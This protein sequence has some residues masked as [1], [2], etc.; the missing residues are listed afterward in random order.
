MSLDSASPAPSPRLR[1]IE[2]S[3]GWSLGGTDQAIEIRAA[4]L[5]PEHFD[6]EAVGLWGGQRFERLKQHGTRGRELGGKLS[7]LGRVLSESRPHVLHYTRADRNCEYSAAV[8]RAA[9]AAAVPVLVETNVFGRPA[10]FAEPR[11]PD[12]TC[13]M[14]LASMLRCAR[15]L[16]T[17]MEEL[18]QRGH[19]AVYLP[20]PTPAGYGAP[21][22]VPRAEARQRLGV[23]PHEL[24]ACRITRPDLRKWSVRLELALPRLFQAVPELRFVFMAAPA[25]KIGWLRR[26]FG[27]RVICVEPQTDLAELA[28]VYAASDL[29]IHSSGIGESFGLSMAEGMFHGLP[30]IVD[31]TP[32]MDNAQVEVV[33]H[34]QSGLVVASSAG[35]V[36]AAER[37]ARDPELRRRLGSAASV[38][39]RECF[40]DRVVVAEW[41]RLYAESS[42]QA[43]IS[44]SA[45]VAALAT[46]PAHPAR[47]AYAQFP[48]LYAELCRRF[49]GPEVAITEV[50]LGRAQHALDTLRQARKLGP[51]AV[52][53]V[54][55]SRLR[56]TG[57]LARD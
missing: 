9:A 41:E 38:R 35:F 7:E 32:D 17:S 23:L 46:R 21:P 39:A 36:A 45:A 2:L 6:V 4:S 3:A 50:L 42:V 20:V 30:V 49:A 43:G 34:E 8:Q 15:Q 22:S 26:R 28:S 27:H 55:R 16:G 53:R 14:S 52:L 29:M 11:T 47:E 12:R 1:V 48:A 13:H 31:S 57:S 25:E 54:V 24:V 18:Y 10:G 5:A 33:E 44:V 40:A 37:L 19:R 51:A 56:S